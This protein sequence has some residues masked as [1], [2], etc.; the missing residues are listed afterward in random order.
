MDSSGL[1]GSGGGGKRGSTPVYIVYSFIIV[2][3]SKT[4]ARWSK[5]MQ[6]TQKGPL[7]V[8]FDPGKLVAVWP[9]ILIKSG[10]KGAGKYFLF[11]FWFFRGSSGVVWPISK[12]LVF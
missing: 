5:I 12:F 9:P 1:K 8:T 10:R 2:Y 4:V 3:L 7:K 11:F 6:N